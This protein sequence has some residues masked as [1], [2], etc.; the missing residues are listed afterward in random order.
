[1]PPVRLAAPGGTRIPG[2]NAFSSV[3]LRGWIA[4]NRFGDASR[5]AIITSASPGADWV[6]QAIEQTGYGELRAIDVRDPENGI[7]GGRGA[8]PAST[9]LSPLA[10]VLDAEAA[11][12]RIASIAGV[13]P[14][15]SVVDVLRTRG[16][17]AWAIVARTDMQGEAALIR[18][19]DGGRSWNYEA[20]AF[21][22][23]V[24]LHDLAR[25]TERR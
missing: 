17:G 8:T 12:W 15:A 7:A 24:E 9:G 14:D 2:P 20:T 10:L 21:E 19:V 3:G 13:A 1:V 11:T 5:A 18:S 22:H 4:F 25:N 23:G 16:D 6:E